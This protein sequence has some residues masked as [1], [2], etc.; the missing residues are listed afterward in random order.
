MS[1]VGKVGTAA[2]LRQRLACKHPTLC[3]AARLPSDGNDHQGWIDS[4]NVIKI[5]GNNGVSSFPSAQRDMHIDHVVMAG[6]RTD[7]ANA[8][9]NVQIHNS[10]LDV[11]R[12]DQT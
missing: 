3:T 2:R 11:E 7:E 4:R 12:L 8:S 9:G 5:A 6:G 1:S 10:D